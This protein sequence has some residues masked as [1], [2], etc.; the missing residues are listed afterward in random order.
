MVKGS[1]I[2]IIPETDNSYHGLCSTSRQ[3]LGGTRN[4]S[5]Q[6][7]IETLIIDLERERE[8]GGER[9]RE[10]ERLKGS[11]S[12]RPHLGSPFRIAANVIL[13]AILCTLLVQMRKGRNVLFNDARNTFYLRLHGV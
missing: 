12:D 7:E 9:E 13:Y 4:S 11:I 10:R 2:C 1:F 6:R 8:R 3:A 5:M